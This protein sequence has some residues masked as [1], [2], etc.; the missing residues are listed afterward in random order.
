[1]HTMLQPEALAWLTQRV[2]KRAKTRAAFDCHSKF[3]WWFWLPQPSMDN[4]REST[5][6]QRT[7]WRDQAEQVEFWFKDAHQALLFKLTFT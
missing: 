5:W 6:Q 7:A 3:R 4:T 2:G 1:M